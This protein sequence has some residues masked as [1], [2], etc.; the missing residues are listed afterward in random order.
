MHNAWQ[1]VSEAEVKARKAQASAERQK[2]KTE[3][4]AWFDPRAAEVFDCP[5]HGAAFRQAV[6]QDHVRSHL[7][8]ADLLPFAQQIRA[9]LERREQSSG[10][11]ALTAPNIQNLVLANF[12]QF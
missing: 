2:K 9:E 1:A 12:R 4:S 6:S 7:G 11:E 5:A 8:T 10:R 3:M